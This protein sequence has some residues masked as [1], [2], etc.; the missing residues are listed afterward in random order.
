MEYAVDVGV[1]VDVDVGVGGVAVTMLVL[2]AEV[3]LVGK[4]RDRVPN[5]N[6]SQTGLF[7][8][9][10]SIPHS[11]LPKKS[12]SL[13]PIVSLILSSRDLIPKKNPN[14]RIV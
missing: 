6:D 3:A 10:S 1:D 5:R 4:W 7:L 13:I 9:S 8:F 12:F 14:N 2:L 11:H